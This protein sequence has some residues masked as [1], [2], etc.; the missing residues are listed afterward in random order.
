MALP[1]TSQFI[2][3]ASWEVNTRKLFPVLHV[4]PCRGLGNDKVQRR[5]EAAEAAW[6]EGMRALSFGILQGQ[7]AQSHIS[8]HHNPFRSQLQVQH[9]LAAEGGEQEAGGYFGYT[10]TPSH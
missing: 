4:S 5:T 6:S 3:S 9:P 8:G 7:H 1:V 10:Q 2:S